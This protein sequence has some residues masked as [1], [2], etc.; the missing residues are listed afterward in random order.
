VV[1]G[2]VLPLTTPSEET[3]FLDMNEQTGNIIAKLGPYAD[4]IDVD[5]R[6]AERWMQRHSE[7][8]TTFAYSGICLL[9][10][11]RIKPLGK[12]P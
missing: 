7:D 11:G 6:P 4:E 9:L 12:C 2:N 10:P 5:M 3:V 1:D 8:K